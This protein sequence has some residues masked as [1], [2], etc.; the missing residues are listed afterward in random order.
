MEN[1]FLEISIYIAFGILIL[2]FVFALIRLFKGP[3]SSDR[4]VALDLIAAIVMGLILLYSLLV[5]REIYFDIAII[6]AM[7]S[8]MGTIGISIHLK[9]KA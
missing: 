2:A 4:I 9:K 1:N 5:K 6:I 7:I 8:F 3:E